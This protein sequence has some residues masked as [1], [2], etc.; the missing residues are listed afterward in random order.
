[1]NEFHSTHYMVPDT[2]TQHHRAVQQSVFGVDTSRVQPTSQLLGPQR[3]CPNAYFYHGLVVLH[4]AQN[5]QG[6]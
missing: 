1:M 3:W 4:R 2:I 5:D 6:A